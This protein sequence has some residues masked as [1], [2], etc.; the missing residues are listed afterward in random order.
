M[1]RTPEELM[2][3]ADYYLSH[4]KVRRQISAAG[5]DKVTSCYTYEKKMR[6]LMEWVEGSM[7]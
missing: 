2:E 3:K 1:F 6:E 7:Q 4:D 5:Y